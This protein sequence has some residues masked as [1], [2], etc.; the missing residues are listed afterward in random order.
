MLR[1]IDSVAVSDN[2]DVLKE[3]QES[4]SDTQNAVVVKSGLAL[5]KLLKPWVWLGTVSREW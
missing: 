5:I 1:P 3:C 4:S 2:Y